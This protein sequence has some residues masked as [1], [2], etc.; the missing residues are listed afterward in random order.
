MS[1]SPIPDSYRV[2]PHLWAGP[3]PFDEDRSRRRER[4]DALLAV[5]VRVVVD[6][7]TP[8]DGPSLRALWERRAP[9]GELAYLSAPVVDGAAPSPALLEAVLDAVDAAVARGRTVYVHCRG[10]LGRTGTVIGAWLVRHGRCAPQEIPSR[11]AELRRGQPH[12]GCPSPETAAQ[13]RL[14]AA[15][16]AGR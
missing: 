12:A 4:V 16:R 13:R 3:W 6:L 9:D 8:A 2:A 11:L 15:W 5:G 10:G 14:L 1:G 7:T